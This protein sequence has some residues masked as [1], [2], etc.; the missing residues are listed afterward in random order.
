[1][2]LRAR[3]LLAVGVTFAVLAVACW[4]LLRTVVLTRFDAIE[5]DGMRANLERAVAAIRQER[6][7]MEQRAFDWAC[8]DDT[9]RWVVDRNPTYVESNLVESTFLTTNMDAIVYAD[10]AGAVV[11]GERYD[12]AS[13]T[14]S[15][16][17][18]ELRR[19]LLRPEYLQTDAAHAIRSGFVLFAEGPA[20]LVTAPIL[21]TMETGPVHGTM[22]MLRFYSAE[23]VRRLAELTRLDLRL[24]PLAAARDALA[25]AAHSESTFAVRT[26]SA[27]QL[28]GSAILAD[29]R[30]REALRLTVQAPRPIHAQGVAAGRLLTTALLAFVLVSGL[31]LFVSLSRFVLTPLVEL[32][33]RV[34][35]IGAVEDPGARIG[36][37]RRD[38]IGKLARDID[39]MLERL[40]VSHARLAD[41]IEELRRTREAAVRDERFR[42]LGQMASGIGHNI[43]NGLV[44]ILSLADLLQR[45]ASLPPAVRERLTTMQAAARG[46]ADSV[47]RL[48]TFYRPPGEAATFAA[49]DLDRTV[50][51]VLTVTQPRW[52]DAPQQHGRNIDVVVESEPG[53]PGLYGDEAEIR[54]ALMN[55]VIN[56]VDAMPAGGRLTI[57]TRRHGPAGLAVEVRDTGAGMSPEVRERCLEPFFTTKGE[58][59]TGLGLAMVHGT[60]RRHDAVLEIES[61]PGAGTTVRLGFPATAPLP[62][63]GKEAGSPASAADA[64]RRVLCIDDEPVVGD[65]IEA[66]MRA[67]GHDVRLERGGEAGLVAFRSALAGGR[68]FDVVVTDLGMPNVDGGQ[69]ARAVKEAAPDVRVILVTGW[70]PFLDDDLEARRWVDHVLSKPVEFDELCALVAGPGGG[71]GSV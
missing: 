1:M 54:E 21:T 42:A 11:W 17:S 48:R 34:A 39:G 36:Y 25:P 45:D 51:D 14:R 65:T 33:R 8:W 43:N 26:A 32:G 29:L 28:E 22:L 46:I 12:A 66:M 69:V 13:K 71:V 5:A 57:A 44:P 50:R 49:F 68:R 64:P 38:E 18:A 70:G 9:Y 16:L 35:E 62:A 27:D 41:A 30:G 63:A 67:A 47:V 55:L 59:G 23:R 10:T 56:A 60:A 53:L 40:A 61:E 15:P 2:T 3:V 6:V 19:E 37:V 58:L 20:L 7:E 52:L 4:V 31:A 24:A